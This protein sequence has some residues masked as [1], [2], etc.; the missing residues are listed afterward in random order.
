[1]VQLKILY[2]QSGFETLP[3]GAGAVND[4]NFGHT[5][6]AIFLERFALHGVIGILSLFALVWMISKALYRIRESDLSFDNT[7]YVFYLLWLML[8]Y[9]SINEDIL[10]YRLLWVF[11]GV[12]L[13][14]AVTHVKK[15]S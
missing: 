12:T 1:M 9:M 6:H 14:V 10:R 5:P 8:A 3:W 11:I 2:L 7:Y 4:L 15:K 13:G